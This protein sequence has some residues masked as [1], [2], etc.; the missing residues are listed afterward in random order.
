MAEQK[1]VLPLK[2]TIGNLTFFKTQDGY[3]AKAKSEISKEKFASDP[4][5]DRT[6]ENMA[7]FANAVEA[8][9]HIRT[10]FSKLLKK[11]SDGRMISRL[12]LKCY[13]VLQTDTVGKRGKRTVAKGD[14]SLLDEFEFNKKGFLSTALV[15]P[16]TVTFTRTTGNVQFD[17]PV[18]IP[19]EDI[20]APK[21][22][23]HYQLQLAAAPVD[24]DAKKDK[25]PATFQTASAFLPW[26][27]NPSA[28]LAL[29]LVLPANSTFPVFILLQI[30]FSELMNGD[31]YPLK[32]G[33]FNAC[34]VIDVDL[35]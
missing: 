23:T 32:N 28:D 29:T 12:S 17:A 25:N 9:K 4:N 10:P 19:K 18:F 26:D 15:A 3:M 33:A 27:N 24:F 34:A 7:E 13:R 30:Q 1:G 35:P 8:G 2:G 6:R 11:S 14:I 20:A 22:A 21:G 31:Y 5:F 16:Y